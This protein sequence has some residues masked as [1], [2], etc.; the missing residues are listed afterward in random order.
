MSIAMSISSPIS[1]G[2]FDEGL[3]I[4]VAAPKM[5]DQLALLA[6]INGAFAEFKPF[7]QDSLQLAPHAF[8]DGTNELLVVAM[9]KPGANPEQTVVEFK[10]T[11]TQSADRFIVAPTH[12]LPD[13]IDVL[14]EA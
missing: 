3:E 5:Q 8:D 6:V 10:D 12:D 9:L 4:S 2:H 1:L 7:H 11:A 13:T 14:V